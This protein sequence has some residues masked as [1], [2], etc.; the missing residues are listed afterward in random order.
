MNWKSTD[1]EPIPWEGGL[2]IGY[3]TGYNPEDAAIALFRYDGNTVYVNGV[4]SACIPKYYQPVPSEQDIAEAIEDAKGSIEDVLAEVGTNID[5][6]FA[7]YRLSRWSYIDY[8]YGNKQRNGALF[9]A[10][11]NKG[12]VV[13]TH[14]CSDEGWASTDLAKGTHEEEYIAASGGEDYEVVMFPWDYYP[15]APDGTLLP[16]YISKSYEEI[17]DAREAARLESLEVPDD[18]T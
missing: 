11:N 9:G 2:F 3:W 5:T 1:E 8:G 16:R 15:V 13:T 17:L 10:V 7:V 18:A 14:F 6:H 4:P 12:E